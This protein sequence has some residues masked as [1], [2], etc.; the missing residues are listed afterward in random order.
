M[1]RF[2]GREGLPSSA[3]RA[4]NNEVSAGTARC[5]GPPLCTLIP[6]KG[7]GRSGRSPTGW[8][9][10]ERKE[11]LEKLRVIRNIPEGAAA[12]RTDPTRVLAPEATV[13][14]TADSLHLIEAHPP[15]HAATPLPTEETP[16]IVSLV[17]RDSK[18]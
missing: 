11:K 3:E 1:E 13:R 9:R 10:K 15:E 8:G 6:Q 5:P 2:R 12:Y 14:H 18:E 7:E 4:G 16:R 17:S